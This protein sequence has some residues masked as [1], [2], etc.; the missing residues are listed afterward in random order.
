MRYLFLSQGFNHFHW[1]YKQGFMEE[2]HT[3]PDEEEG[4]NLRED[5]KKKKS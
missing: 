1:A 2:L 3:I 4:W 5:K